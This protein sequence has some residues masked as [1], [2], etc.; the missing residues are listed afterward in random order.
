MKFKKINLPLFLF[1]LCLGLNACNESNP[2]TAE[3]EIDSVAK[4]LENSTSFERDT[5]RK[6]ATK[7]NVKTIQNPRNINWYTYDY[8]S[9]DV[10]PMEPTPAKIEEM[11]IDEVTSNQ[12]KEVSDLNVAMAVYTVSETDRPPLFKSS[13]LKASDPEQCSN[14]AIEDF[15]KSNIDFPN[16][17]ITKGHDGL[18]IVSFVINEEGEIDDKIEVLSK[19]KPC[20]GCAK[21]AVDVVAGMENWSPALVNGKPVKVR[22][23][24]PIRFKTTDQISLR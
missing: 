4:V 7:V 24:L 5:V 18:E 17:A 3:K 6:D 21:A 16:K 15:V 13:C 10:I 2:Q 1:L 20:K 11:E 14:E 9:P 23:S 19:D 22:V 12:K 8:F